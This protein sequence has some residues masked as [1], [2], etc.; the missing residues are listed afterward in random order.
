MIKHIER[1]L[2][3]TSTSTRTTLLILNFYS[4]TAERIEAWSS[5]NESFLVAFARRL[6][7]VVNKPWRLECYQCQRWVHRLCGTG[8]RLAEY[9]D[10]AKRLH[11]GG[12]F[13]WLCPTCSKTAT[14]WPLHDADQWKKTTLG[15]HAFSVAGPTL[16]NSLPDHLWD[17]AVDSEQF[18]R[19][20][21]RGVHIIALY[22][23]TFT[24]LLTCQQQQQQSF[25]VDCTLHCIG[26]GYLCVC[27]EILLLMPASHIVVMSLGRVLS[28]R[29][30]HSPVLLDRMAVKD[31]LVKQVREDQK[32]SHIMFDY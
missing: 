17:P 10:I 9:R 27:R 3:T 22:K 11:D 5:L 31:C 14:P 1:D 21:I 8:I 24:Y 15:T 7:A 32:M 16:W 12:E 23:S 6:S 29:R 18:R 19:Q 20:R 13:T 25:L 28:S 26:C 2:L 30:G 4:T